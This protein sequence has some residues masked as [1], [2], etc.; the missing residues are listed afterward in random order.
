MCYNPSVS[1][2][3][4]SQAQNT[5]VNTETKQTTVVSPAN[6]SRRNFILGAL[7]GV[8]TSMGLGFLGHMGLEIYDGSLKEK[9]EMKEEEM[10]RRLSKQNLSYE[11]RKKAT[12]NVKLD[13]EYKSY[14]A[15]I[16]EEKT[17]VIITD[18][19]VAAVNGAVATPMII[20]H[21]QEYAN[22]S[23]SETEPSE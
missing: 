14:V 22:L 3:E 19:V 9:A 8:H 1:K 5:Q 11:E 23:K 15:D 17:F 2:E 13:P 4:V 7:A 10:K 20:W 6:I 18:G 21:K 16:K 12:D